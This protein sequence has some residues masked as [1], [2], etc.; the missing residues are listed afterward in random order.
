MIILNKNRSFF[1]LKKKKKKKKK[2][3]RVLVIFLF[4]QRNEFCFYPTIFGFSK[5]LNNN[6]QKGLL[7]FEV[8]NRILL[9]NLNKEDCCSDFF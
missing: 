1:F 7:Y 9:D 8:G 4:G 6:N 2:K 5:I 3:K